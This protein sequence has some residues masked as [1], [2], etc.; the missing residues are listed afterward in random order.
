[1]TELIGQV[2][3][4]SPPLAQD[5]RREVEALSSRRPF[6]LNFER[7]I[8]ELVH[9]P[10]RQVRRGDKVVLRTQGKDSWADGPRVVIGFDGK[11]AKRTATL[12]SRDGDKS[13]NTSELV[14]ELVVVAEFRDPIYPGLRSSGKVERG[15]DR[16]HHVVVN[17][18]NYH[19]L[20]ALTFVHRGRIDCIYIDPPYNTRDNDWKYNNDYVDSDDAYRHSKWLA[21][22][23]RRLR[24]S[25]A[26]LNPRDSVLIVT[27]DEKEYLRLGLLLQQVFPEARIQ[28]VSS[29]IAQ[30][31]VAR[32]QQFYR[33]DEY[34][35]FVAFG[36][37]AVI[38]QAL[39]EDWQLG[40]G[41]SA[42]AGGIVWSQLRRSGTNSRREDRPTL[43]YPLFIDPDG[44]RIDSLGDSL[45]IDG[46]PSLVE[47][48]NG[49][50]ALWPVRSDGTYGNW[51]QSQKALRKLI[52]QGYVRVGSAN[53][54]GYPVSYLKR[55]SIEKITTGKV[56]VLGRDPQGG[57]V[58][59]DSAEYE[60]RFIPGTS[61]NIASH[62]A[63]YHGTQLLNRFIGQGRF[64]F[65]KSLYAVEDAL[66]FY[67]ADKPDALILDF[68]AGS[69]TTAH[70]VMRLNKQDGGLR[71][72]ILVTNNEVSA[73]EA[74]GLSK[75]GLRPGDEDW[76]ALGI[77]KFVTQPRIEAAITGR[78]PEGSEV[79]GDYRFT[80]VFPM[81]DGFSENAE[82]F[83]LSYEDPEQVQFGRGF[84]AIAP[85]LWMRA[86]C[87]GRRIENATDGFDIADTYG[88]LFEIDHAAAFVQGIREDE[89]V[90]LAYIVTDDES[91]F[92]AVAAQLPADVQSV[93]LYSAYLENF[94]IAARG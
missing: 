50:I 25:K 53:E 20:E 59:T 80:D 34:I 41:A 23:E 14:S 27:I 85:L 87:S 45:P 75:R 19:V 5:L 90:V 93:R 86:G 44:P 39:G 2:E 79:S 84:E 12:A 83:D 88:V 81:R 68:F 9:L 62:D 72:A 66:R 57:H 28:M 52:E 92:Q 24:L 65:P 82:F 94:Q 40:K 89:R 6:G 78:T 71:R 61:W 10:D 49:T 4:A 11:G 42:A 7:H 58:L 46:D 17:G 73:E 13:G 54:S 33:T 18:E 16:P 70:A 35:F 74:R 55:G 30:K 69:G 21:M 38:P 60:H 64:P 22:M 67:V 91:Q 51:Q 43:F 31:G 37:A 1:L 56:A 26:L 15:G 3:K 48:P 8:P 47:A 77:C 63:T 36:E 32:R 29:V 76:E